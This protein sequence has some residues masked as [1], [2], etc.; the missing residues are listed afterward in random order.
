MS[1]LNRLLFK[2]QSIDKLRTLPCIER[3]YVKLYQENDTIV[4][5]GEINEKGRESFF[6]EILR[7]PLWNEIDSSTKIILRNFM[8]EKT[9]TKEWGS[10]Y[11]AKWMKDKYGLE[12]IS[13]CTVVSCKTYND[14]S[15]FCYDGTTPASL[16]NK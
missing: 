8:I 15:F 13:E 5:E 12:C 10:V 4:I 14:S 7:S 6:I 9:D 3:Q 16:F 2:M 11:C 1:L